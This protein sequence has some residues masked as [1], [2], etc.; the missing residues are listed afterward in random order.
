MGSIYELVNKVTI[1]ASP[2]GG[3]GIC[4]LYVCIHIDEYISVYKPRTSLPHISVYGWRECLFE[5]MRLA[6]DF[7]H[8]GVCALVCFL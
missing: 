3:V 6:N 1:L 8:R 2:A 5:G 7:D 4:K